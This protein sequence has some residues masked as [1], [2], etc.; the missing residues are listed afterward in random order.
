[1]QKTR[2]HI[3]VT[4]DD[5]YNSEGIRLVA[6]MLSKYGDVTVVAP[7]YPQSGKSAALTLDAP[8]RCNKIASYTSRCNTTVTTYALTGT[9]ADS[10]KWAANYIYPE[11]R[12]Q[13]VVSGINHGSNTSAA[14]VYS[15]TLGAAAEGCLWGVPSIG[16]SID[17]HN[18]SPDF[19]GIEKYLP[20]LLEK[21]IANPPAEGTYYNINFPNL[22]AEKIK[23]IKIASQGKGRWVREYEK[24]TDPKGAD[25]YWMTGNFE[26]LETSFSGDHRFVAEGY[27]SI[28]P[29][30][31]DNTDYS[32]MAELEKRFN[33]N[34][35]I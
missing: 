4:N 34:S 35:E 18:P 31:V 15:G 11:N 23:G 17:T 27:I 8:L 26:D 32:A 1:M 22:P 16:I 33:L 20:E 30:K 7:K 25:Y 10:V 3:L 13:L 21:I 24:R 12:P 29:H 9:P 5:S 6:E 14:S 19:S 28:V 2:L